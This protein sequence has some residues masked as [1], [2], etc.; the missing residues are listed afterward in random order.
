LAVSGVAR[1]R[2]QVHERL[3]QLVRVGVNH[4]EALPG[5]E[6][7]LDVLAHDAPDDLE[8]PR[9]EVVQGEG[10]AAQR[11]APAEGEELVGEFGGAIGQAADLG[12]AAPERP[13]GRGPVGGDLGVGHH[14]GEEVVELVRD[15]AGEFAQRF[16]GGR[17]DVLDDGLGVILGGV[18]PRAQARPQFRTVAAPQAGLETG[19]L[20]RLE[21]PGQEFGPGVGVQ[22]HAMP[23]PGAAQLLETRVAQHLQQPVVAVERRPVGE[24]HAAE[25][26][27]RVAVQVA[28]VALALAEGLVVPH[29]LDR[30]AQQRGIEAQA[31]RQVVRRGRRAGRRRGG[32]RP[33]DAPVTVLDR[34]HRVPGVGRLAP[35][36]RIGR[37][38]RRHAAEHATERSRIGD[39]QVAAGFVM[40]DAIGVGGK[41]AA[42]AGALHLEQPDAHPG[43]TQPVA[44]Q[45]HRPAAKAEFVRLDSQARGDLHHGLQLLGVSAARGVLVAEP[46]LGLGGVARPHEVLRQAGERRVHIE[47]RLLVRQDDQHPRPLRQGHRQRRGARAFGGGRPLGPR[48]VNPFTVQDRRG[49]RRQTLATQSREEPFPVA[50][51]RLGR[52]ARGAFRVEDRRPRRAEAAGLDEARA[53]AL[54]QPVGVALAQD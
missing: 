12:E 35:G 54:E 45:F 1:V 38:Q 46:G 4:P 15:T 16:H 5:R 34:D 41:G 18:E 13:V 23:R 24:P 53:H 50:N 2:R 27:R 40:G 39:R 33:E 48:G 20:A 32:Q 42:R 14:A 21:Q 28:E 17:L 29:G 3:F 8:R 10:S 11:L 6:P 37:L 19:H 22:E 47:I 44:R 25:P 36:A 51:A 49:A 43:E 26:H 9:D 31:L 30:L 52:L 7:H